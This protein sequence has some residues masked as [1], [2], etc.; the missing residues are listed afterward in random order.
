[1][2]KAADWYFDFVSPYSY[3]QCERLLELPLE[4]RAR[5]LV[6]AGLLGH[7]GQ[8][9]PAELTTKRR[10]TYQQVVWLARRDA[11]GLRFP[12]KHPFN[13]IKALRLAVALRSD[14][15]A[16]RT[17]F[18]YIWR[19]G[20][21]F[22]TPEGWKALCE[23]LRVDDGD[24]LVARQGVKDELR[25]NGDAALAA[26]VF[27]VPTLVIDERIFWGYDATPMAHEY[28]LHPE[29][30]DSDEMKRVADLPVGKARQ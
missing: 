5:P 15:D 20:G 30:F 10:F 3:L 23:R 28:L 9:G 11:I 14:I 27:G 8:K 1:M 13:P 2:P 18:R 21:E 6:F 24:G 7:W 22:D 19:D 4:V 16:I 25:A 17:I 26:G 12:P 29:R